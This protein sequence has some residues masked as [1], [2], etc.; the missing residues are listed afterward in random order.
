MPEAQPQQIPT[1]VWLLKS[2]GVAP[3]ALGLILAVIGIVLVIRPNRTASAI[4]AF[5]SLLPAIFGL[6][7]VYSAAADYAQMA[8]SP[9]P[10]KPAEFAAITGR[11]MSY[12]FCGLLG[13][14]LPVF[15]V[16]LALSRACKSVNA[17]DVGTKSGSVPQ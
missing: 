14:I 15:I 10:P 16:V 17:L 2:G 8:V 3:L 6:I 9:T 1:I 12:S 5:L 7:V 13:T 4:L 11:A